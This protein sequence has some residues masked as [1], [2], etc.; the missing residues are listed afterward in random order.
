[1]FEVIKKNRK[2]LFSPLDI[3]LNSYFCQAGRFWGY[4]RGCETHSGMENTADCIIITPALHKKYD[5]PKG[6]DS[7][8]FSFVSSILS[9]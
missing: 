4:G 5:R 2:D 7:I 1:M 6:P 8:H 3:S 9:S